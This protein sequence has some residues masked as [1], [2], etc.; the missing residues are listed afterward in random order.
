M[1]LIE[2]IGELKRLE[3]AGFLT[4]SIMQIYVFTDVMAYLSMPTTQTKQ[5]RSDFIQWVDKYMQAAE[6][7][8]YKYNGKDFYAARCAVLHTFSAEADFHTKNPDALVY[9]YHDGGKHLYNPSESERLVLIGMPSLI[10]DFI[11]GVKN[12]LQDMKEVIKDENQRQVLD[13][14]MKKILRTLP[15]PQ[16][17]PMEHSP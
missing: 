6:S 1:P 13:H 7:Q 11:I 17:Q 12:F 9:G 16:L 3:Q 15:F 4:A 8:S 5:E 10:N 14:R 2:M